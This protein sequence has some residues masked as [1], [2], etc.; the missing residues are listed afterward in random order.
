VERLPTQA[1][2]SPFAA[3]CIAL[4]STLHRPSQ[5][6][7]SAHPS[8]VRYPRLLAMMTKKTQRCTFFNYLILVN[9]IIFANFVGKYSINHSLNSHFICQQ[10]EIS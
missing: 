3:A 5:L 4:R 10:E 8:K 9:R 7:A 6:P 2:A 1:A